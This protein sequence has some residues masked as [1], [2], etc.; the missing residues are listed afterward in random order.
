MSYL[1]GP[2]GRDEIR[3]LMDPVRARGRGGDSAG[4]RRS[5]GVASCGGASLPRPPAARPI[6]PPDVPQYFAPGRGAAW[7]PMLVGA[8]RLTYSDAKLGLDE[9]SDIVVWTPLT[10]GPVPVDWEHAEPADFTVDA[11]A[12]EPGDGGTFASLPAAAA[13]PRN[14]AAWTKAFSA[15]AARSQSVELL[16]STRLKLTSDPGET[17]GDFRVRVQHALRE[18]RDAALA[19]LRAR[20]AAKLTALDDRIRRASQA[21]QK[22]SEQATEQ[23]VSTAVSVGATVLGALFGRKAVSVGTLGR[24]TTAARGVSRMGREAQ[25]VARAQSTLEALTA[26]RDALAA[27]LEADVQ[28][29]QA[30]WSGEGETFERV[31]VKPKRGGVQTQVV[32]LVWRPTP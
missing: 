20:Q 1:R 7:V 15:W 14:Y 30:E 5:R 28:Q 17:E 8:A 25:D 4:Q 11:L 24:A 26:Q 21:V 9:T 2:M 22:E 12:G 23:K 10:D 16:R 3:A 18:K 27:A 29:V 6:L 31:V 32:A 13:K 19:A